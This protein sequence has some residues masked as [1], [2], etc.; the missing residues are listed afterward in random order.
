MLLLCGCT[1]EKTTPAISADTYFNAVYTTGDF[2]YNCTVKRQ[3]GTVF[4]TVN[5]TNAAGLTI[6]CDGRSIVFTK[7]AM[8][9]RVNKENVDSTNPALLLWEIFNAIDNGSSKCPLGN[10]SAEYENG[11]L[12]RIT[13]DEITVEAVQQ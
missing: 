2:S 1:G 9:K 8:I 11:T 4:V 6:S 3:K 10:F 7:G 12:K 5:S 13:V